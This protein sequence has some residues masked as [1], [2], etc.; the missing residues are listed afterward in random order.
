MDDAEFLATFEACRW[1]LERWHHCDHVKLAYLY[2][3]R[4][5]LDEAAARLRAGIQAHNAAHAIPESLTSGYHE[6][7]TQAW[8]RLVHVILCEYGPA[9]TADAFCD[10][11]PE[12]LEKKTLR[13]FYSRER[14]LSAEAKVTFV[15]PDLAPLP[16]SPRP[17]DAMV[18]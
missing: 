11:H 4:H 1:P 9:D 12:L 17:C 3:R 8:L 6:T 14:F 15:E 7:M 5:P 13:L 18:T 2:L 10:A 16:R